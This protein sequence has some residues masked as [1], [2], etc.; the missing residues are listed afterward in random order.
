VSKTHDYVCQYLAIW[1]FYCTQ[2]HF[3]FSSRIIFCILHS[4]TIRLDKHYDDF[5]N[6][7]S[8]CASEVSRHTGAIQI[9]LIRNVPVFSDVV[10]ISGCPKIV[11]KFYFYCRKITVQKF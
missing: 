6:A 10:V 4:L 9:S 1:F 2:T 7:Y 5:T 3:C 11:A 8:R